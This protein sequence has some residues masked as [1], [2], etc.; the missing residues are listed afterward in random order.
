MSFMKKIEAASRSIKDTKAALSCVD[1]ILEHEAEDYY[2]QAGQNG[3]TQANWEKKWDKIHHIYSDAL[4]A[5]GGTPDVGEF[6]A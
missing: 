4:K 5:I 2:E 3:I 6:D 1:Y